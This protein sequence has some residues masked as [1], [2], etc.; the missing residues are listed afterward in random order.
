VGGRPGR[1]RSFP[2]ALACALRGALLAAR[3]QPHLRIQLLLASGALLLAAWAGVSFVELA[4]LACAIGLVLAMELLN[5]AVEML[6]DLLHPGVDHRAGA[7]K[8]TA[9]AAVLV[10]SALAAAGGAFVFLPHVVVPT[11]LLLRGLPL[12]LAAGALGGF[13]AGA[14]RAR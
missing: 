10:A 12:L 3:T 2:E 11:P 4:F 1:P 13:L 5:T 7:V 14:V 9:A 6:T 8:D